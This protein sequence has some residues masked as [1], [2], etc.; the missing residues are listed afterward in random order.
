MNCDWV[1]ANVALYVY[2]ELPDDARYELKRHVSRC[3]ECAAELEELRAFTTAISAISAPEPAPNLLAGSR[4]RLQ[5]ALE[6]TEPHRG[7][8]RWVLE[9]AYWFHQIKLAPAVA[10][11]LFMIGFG[12]GVGATYRMVGGDSGVR[13]IDSPR[14]GSAVAPAAEEASI[15]GIRGISQQP[16]SGRVDIKYDTIV[17][18]KLTGSPDEPGSSSCSCSRRTTALTPVCASIP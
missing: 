1:R 14:A 16:G 8:H 15:L 6:T 2:D 17:P 11:L 18:Q 9:P 7:W 10:A 5:E 4:L 13:L 12:A 3:G